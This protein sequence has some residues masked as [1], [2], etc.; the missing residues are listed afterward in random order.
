MSGRPGDDASTLV[1]VITPTLNEAANI[2][3]LIQGV[4]DAFASQGLEYEI[5][6]ADGGSAD[7]TQ[8]LV[9]AW[10]GRAPVRL[11]TSD[12]C[13]GLAGDVLAAAAQASGRVVVVLDADLSH[14]VDVAPVLAKHVLSG[15]Y[16]MAIG[17]R[18]VKGGRTPGWGW[19]RRVISRAATL[20]AAPLVD[21][22]DPMSGFFAVSRDR[23][24]TV[25]PSAKGFK[26]GLEALI[27]GGD[28]LRVVEVPIS[29]R[30]R[31]HGVSKIGLK[32]VDF[33]LRRLGSLAGASGGTRGTLRGTLAAL[34]GVAVDVC[35]FQAL[36][37]AGAALST[38]HIGGFLA[39]MVLFFLF[40]GRWA[41]VP[42]S[43]HRLQWSEIPRF[44]V[45][46]L[47]TLFLRGGILVLL[48]E[49]AGLPEQLAILSAAVVGLLVTLIGSVFFV[50]APSE[51][52][53]AK[54]IAW[55]VAA[56]GVVGYVLI[57]RLAYL[58]LPDLLPEEAYYWNYSQHLDL[59]YLDHP[60][61][62][63]WLIAA[64]TS[65]FGDTEFGVRVGALVCWA[66]AAYFC[67]GFAR[68]LADRGTAIRTLM[69]VAVLP[70]FFVFGMFM[71]PDAPLIA[72]WAASLFFLERALLGQN[73][74]AWYGFG[75]C[76][77]LGMLS[78]YTIALL[79]PAAAMFVVLDRSS[80]RWLLRPEPYVAVIL[81]A[82]VF[83]PVIVW[84]YQNEW[85]SFWFQGPRRINR[86]PVFSLHLL[87]A[88]AML[89]ITPIGVVGCLR[90]VMAKPPAS[91]LRSVLRKG[92]GPD[93]RRRLFVAVFTL[94][95]LSVFVLFS[96]RH[97]PKLSWT[98]PIWLAA[99]PM[100][101]REL[102]P[103]LGAKDSRIELAGRR[104]WAPTVA[105]VLLL[106][107]GFLHYL[108]LGL[109]GVGYSPNMRLPV[110]WEEL[111]NQVER[112]EEQIE[113]RSGIEPLIVGMD[114]YF[115]ASGL[116]FYRRHDDE[117]V[118]HSTS[119]HLF[120]RNGLMY[121][122]WFPPAE[123]AG[124]T[125]ILVA[126]DLE[127]LADDRLA[128]YADKLGE[129]HRRAVVKDG[130]RVGWYYYR[131]ASGYLP[132]TE[133]DRPSSRLDFTLARDTHDRDLSP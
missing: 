2:D 8:A 76:I 32:Q 97:A 129:I 47:L 33:Y 19:T 24:L 52:P 100:L 42:T 9:Q 91:Q 31:M 117:G 127:D 29:F 50:W 4:L 123:H 58:G 103:T 99:L 105:T 85:A 30:D 69:L 51:T 65:I 66:V 131:I 72:F 23:L 74:D 60:P 13:G 102:T 121:A 21:V 104:M 68:N 110:A 63:A 75:L 37:G 44:L 1:S 114:K 25:D 77:G 78:K 116:A 93:R 83:S 86:S 41:F 125:L 36:R 57:L 115:L 6:V 79:M 107:G 81:A 67:Y 113:S 22:R 126:F 45:L 40:N 11:V 95:P 34:L 94:V 39:A 106:F 10:E 5:L 90:A 89:L 12:G 71:T 73:R 118:A 46:L 43:E 28:H 49:R 112:L 18:Y 48:I 15:S 20:L 16:D 84:N 111:A 96:L 80:R 132:I 87:V 14:P 120:D 124:R 53:L 64:G 35:A 61:M 3:L 122:Y 62:V 128:G 26:I 130:R 119:R 56:V 27:A 17:S 59:G 7:G 88:S 82:I 54:G 38:A 101:A 109:P 133:V 108:V 70:F 98:G 55:R 92:G